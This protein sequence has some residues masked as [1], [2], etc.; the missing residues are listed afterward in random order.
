MAL[1]KF[2]FY[3]AYNFCIRVLKEKEFPWAWASLII[4]L[5]LVTSIVVLLEVMEYLMLP[6]RID[7]YGGF[8]GYFALAAWIIIQIYITRNKRYLKIIED[9][10]NLSTDRRKNLSLVSIIYISIL[11]VSFF[12][13]GALIRDY[14]LS[15]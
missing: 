3:K 14:N 8:H 2:I 11:I 1:Y 15:H 5:C 7:I 10:E 9:C 6:K 4:T 12:G 13:L